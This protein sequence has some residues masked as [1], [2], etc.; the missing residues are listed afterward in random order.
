MWTIE[1]LIKSS[2]F[3][4]LILTILALFF[5]IIVTSFWPERVF[6]RS[7]LIGWR[8][9]L[10]SATVAS[11]VIAVKVIVEKI[12]G[13]RPIAAH[14]PEPGMASFYSVGVEFAEA[15]ILL[16]PWLLLPRLRAALDFRV[17]WSWIA[18]IFLVLLSSRLP[19]CFTVIGGYN[20]LDNTV[21]FS[22]AMLIGVVEETVF[23]GYAFQLEPARRPKETI[24]VTATFFA[25]LHLNDGL[26]SW[27]CAGAFAAGIAFGVVRLAT[28]SLGLCIVLHGVCDIVAFTTGF[29]KCPLLAFAVLATAALF[30][31]PSCRPFPKPHAQAFTPRSQI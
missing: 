12:A 28:G 29:D 16:L 20:Y 13:L 25:L 10:F 24:I 15:V 2:S 31:H 3:A 19:R 17:R 6:K 26:L 4:L 8:R 18:L 9:V 21:L 30:L 27:H 5:L 11:V 1:S 14:R 22:F 23:R 7:S